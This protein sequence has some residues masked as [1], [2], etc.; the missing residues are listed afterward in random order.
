MTTN[1]KKIFTGQVFDIDGKDT[2]SGKYLVKFRVRTDDGIV[3]CIMWENDAKRFTSDIKEDEKVYFE[4]YDKGGD[5]NIKYFKSTVTEKSSKK[6]PD[7]TEKELREYREKRVKLGYEFIK[8]DVS[9]QLKTVSKERGYCVKVNGVWEG[10]TEYAMKVLG[11]AYVSKALSE[12]GSPDMKSASALLSK[13]NP[14]SFKEVINDL[15]AFAASETGDTLE[16]PETEPKSSLPVTAQ[17]AVFNDNFEKVE[18]NA[19]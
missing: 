6:A 8:T 7:V 19:A 10:K 9:G 11:G 13:A 5:I 1:T 3:P 18:P 14:V 2:I 15:V 16:W 17:P 4:G 12:F